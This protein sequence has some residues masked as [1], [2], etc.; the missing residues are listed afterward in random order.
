MQNVEWVMGEWVIPLRLLRLLEHLEVLIILNDVRFRGSPT[1]NCA[2]IQCF[3]LLFYVECTWTLGRVQYTDAT[4]LQ[5]GQYSSI[6]LSLTS[7][8]SASAG[9]VCYHLLSGL[10][11][12]TPSQCP[13]GSL[14]SS[15]AFNI[16]FGGSSCLVKRKATQH[17]EVLSEF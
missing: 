10:L 9:L 16:P 6:V 1:I 12:L 11:Y 15:N 3:F 4:V 7:G 8:S 14:F 2:L 13:E 17:Y 5:L